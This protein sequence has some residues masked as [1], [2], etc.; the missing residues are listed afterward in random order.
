MKWKLFAR[1]W[2]PCK[3]GVKFCV[4]IVWKFA[5]GFLLFFKMQ[6]QYIFSKFELKL[7]LK[8]SL[9]PVFLINFRCFSL[10]ACDNTLERTKQETT[11]INELK[12]LAEIQKIKLAQ[13]V[14]P[15]W[16]LYRHPWSVSF[17]LNIQVEDVKAAVEMEHPTVED[18]HRGRDRDSVGKFFRPRGKTWFLHPFI[19]RRPFTQTSSWLLTGLTCFLRYYW[20]MRLFLS[21][22]LIRMGLFCDRTKEKTI[23]SNKK[24]WRFFHLTRA[25]RT[26][27]SFF[28]QTWL[29]KGLLAAF[30]GGTEL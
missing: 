27:T 11:K 20:P 7:F 13:K 16:F 3:F 10:H 25:I 28:V 21:L 24:F 12:S 8:H 4:L 30:Y 6:P 9:F 18:V 5:V 26:T 15:V 22:M 17:M 19:A 1:N 23:C 14:G 29:Q 2:I